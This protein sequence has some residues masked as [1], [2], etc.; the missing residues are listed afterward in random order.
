[1]SKNEMLFNEQDQ[2]AIVMNTIHGVLVTTIQTPLSPSVIE[3][4]KYDILDRLEHEKIN[5]IFFDFS[6][7]TIM[8]IVEFKAIENI[9]SMAKMMGS[10]SMLVGL[11]PGIV[12]SLVLY[13][14]DSQSLNTA[15]DVDDAFTRLD[16]QAD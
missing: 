9:I 2:S 10:D 16:L 15:L 6:G 5:Y 12:A 11:H 4:F 3:R 13:D 7:L 8:D 14:I 1:M